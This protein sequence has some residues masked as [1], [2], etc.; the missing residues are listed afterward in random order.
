MCFGVC[1]KPFLF[2]VFKSTEVDLSP[3][4]IPSITGS[5]PLEKHNNSKKSLLY[6]QLAKW[7]CPYAC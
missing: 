3:S 6:Q 4:L 7:Y 5:W 1:A 2:S